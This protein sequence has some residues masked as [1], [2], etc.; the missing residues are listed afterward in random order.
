MT[1]H[2]A[3]TDSAVELLAR[4][5]TCAGGLVTA[6]YC[7]DRVSGYAP[8]LWE[9]PFSE[10][11]PPYVSAG[12]DLAAYLRSRH[13]AVFTVECGAF[14]DPLMR[15]GFDSF[16]IDTLRVFPIQIGHV[17]HFILTIGFGQGQD[18]DCN[19]K[20]GLLIPQL[21]NLLAQIQEEARVRCTN[22]PTTSLTGSESA[23][24]LLKAAAEKGPDLLATTLL[25]QVDGTHSVTIENNQGVILG[26]APADAEKR[27]LAE[28]FSSLELLPCLEVI[29][30]RGTAQLVS[31]ITDEN[32]ALAVIPIVDWHHHMGYIVLECSE[33][34]REVLSGDIIWAANFSAAHVMHRK[35]ASQGH[36]LHRILASV[37]KDRAR[38]ARELQ[39]ETSQNL[40]ALNVRLATAASL[41]SNGAI[42]QARGIIEDCSAIADNILA[43]VNHLA[44]DLR[45][46]ELT[47]L[48]LA[49]AIRAAAAKR[50][51]RSGIQF[52]LTGNALDARLSN[53][54]EIMLLN[55]I[56]EAIANCAKHSE[57]TLVEI[58]MDEDDSWLNI[59]VRDNGRGFDTTNVL[60]RGSSE[61][62]GVRYM[63]ACAESI[64]AM[65]WIGSVIGSGT[66]IRFSIPINVIEVGQHE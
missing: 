39:D 53:L 7:K 20:V 35:A 38:V 32:K 29:E 55:G 56:T 9:S 26:N 64:D 13:G 66:T 36:Q 61:G 27:S 54:Q 1:S 60:T 19:V 31:G 49:D 62:V 34:V 6:L 51:R 52:E 2:S 47:Y 11:A 50:L 46:S 45:P 44:S 63:R 12:S 28:R 42:E 57:A 25:K 14:K 23:L 16:N 17:S 48:G 5:R 15:K 43:G 33:N 30:R 10:A 65:F 24:T 4:I 37:D 58:S 21:R 59:A 40:V 3:H 18:T 8:L 41:L 22:L